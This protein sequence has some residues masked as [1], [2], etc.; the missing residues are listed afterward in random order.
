MRSYAFPKDDIMDNHSFC[1]TLLSLA[2][3]EAKEAGVKVPKKL[4]ALESMGQYFIEG[5]GI[6][7][8][9]VSADCV[10]EAKAKYI[11]TLLPG[12]QIE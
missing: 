1:R 4:S 11:D 10:Y 6:E 7:G 9:W 2:R 12:N 8:V 5:E 3:E